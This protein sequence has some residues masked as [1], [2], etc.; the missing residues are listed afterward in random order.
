MPRPMVTKRFINPCA[1][2]SALTLLGTL[3]SWALGFLNHLGL[4]I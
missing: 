2:S 4:S 1:L 3:Q